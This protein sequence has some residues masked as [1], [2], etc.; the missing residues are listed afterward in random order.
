MKAGNL[1]LFLSLSLIPAIREAR[2][3]TCNPPPEMY[4]MCAAMGCTAG[5][6]G[7]MYGCGQYSNGVFC[8][9]QWT[10]C[11]GQN[12]CCPPGTTCGAGNTCNSPMPMPM[13]APGPFPGQQPPWQ[14]PPP[15]PPPGPCACES[16]GLGGSKCSRGCGAKAGNICFR[17]N[18]CRGGM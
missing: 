6:F 4:M 2:G 14:P 7:G 5:C 13:P 12:W 11:S 9:C 1:V 3:E 18:N 17:L 10:G 16:D 8:A 15:P